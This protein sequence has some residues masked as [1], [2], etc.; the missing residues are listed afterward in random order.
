MLLS[1]Y[2]FKSQARDVG[3]VYVRHRKLRR[4]NLTAMT[5]EKAI[6]KKI[7]IKN[8]LG[9]HIRAAAKFVNVA[10]QYSVKIQV[11]HKNKI[12]NGKSV[13]ALMMLAAK[14]GTI[15]ELIASGKDATKTIVTLSTLIDSHFGE[16][17]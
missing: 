14:Q 9:L 11:R 16:N 15:L 17:S 6:S 3:D 1:N 2:I 10:N 12:I 13:M 8:R 5:S 4:Q 7:I